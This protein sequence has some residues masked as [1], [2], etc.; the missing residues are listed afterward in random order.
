MYRRAEDCVRMADLTLTE[1]RKD[2]FRLVDEMIA[3]GRPLRV[4]RGSR[5]V[6]LKTRVL[7]D[8]TAKSLTPEERWARFLEK[9]ER[10]TTVSAEFDDLEYGHWTWRDEVDPR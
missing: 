8:P 10:Q 3:T 9:P 7:D 5:V 4:R 6:E 1:V 2:L